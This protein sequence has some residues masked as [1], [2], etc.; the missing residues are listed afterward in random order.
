MVRIR[1]KMPP[2]QDVTGV[3][4]RANLLTRRGDRVPSSFGWSIK[5]D[6]LEVNT[7][8]RGTKWV[9][10]YL[11]VFGVKSNFVVGVTT[12]CKP[13]SKESAI[14]KWRLINSVEVW[15]RGQ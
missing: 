10:N 5:L 7:H 12:I 6:L 9:D 13:R 1:V 8:G 15:R 3:K 4:V 2:R 11:F 14:I